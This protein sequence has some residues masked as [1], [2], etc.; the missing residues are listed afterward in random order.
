MYYI[1]SRLYLNCKI[2]SNDDSTQHIFFV[3]G[4]DSDVALYMDPRIIIIHGVYARVKVNF[5]AS[6]F[7]ILNVMKIS[8]SISLR[9]H[10]AHHR[11]EFCGSL[12][13]AYTALQVEKNKT[14]P[15]T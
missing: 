7:V 12:L 5:Y 4:R 13:G 15:Q 3:E 2:T 9:D 6:S 1:H 14:S 10:C 11:A 8:D